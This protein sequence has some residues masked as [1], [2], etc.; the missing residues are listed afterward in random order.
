MHRN[1]MSASTAAANTTKKMTPEALRNLQAATAAP[2]KKVTGY[3]GAQNAA[4]ASAH[5]GFTPYPDLRWTSGP[6][7]PSYEPWDFC[8]PYFCDLCNCLPEKCA[9]FALHF[10]SDPVREAQCNAMLNGKN[11]FQTE[12]DTKAGRTPR[13]WF[14]G[15]NQLEDPEAKR[16]CFRQGWD[17]AEQQAPAREATLARIALRRMERDA[18]TEE[19]QRTVVA[20]E[21]ALESVAL[22]FRKHMERE[23]ELSEA[24]LTAAAAELQRAVLDN[25]AALERVALHRRKLDA[26]TEELQRTVVASEA[27][28]ESAALDFR[29]HR[30]ARVLQGA[31]RRSRAQK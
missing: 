19:L 15:S 25:E 18:D 7:K 16:M 2:T 10:S 14:P 20:S 26:D 11:A 1:I 3:W 28:L 8:P 22:D 30:A 31:A 17:I 6:W 13:D 27:A 23:R 12:A 4:A 24:K 9:H 29:K 21:A 5:P